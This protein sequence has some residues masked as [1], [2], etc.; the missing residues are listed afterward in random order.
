MRMKAQTVNSIFQQT[1]V[2]HFI[3]PEGNVKFG[4]DYYMTPKTTVGFVVSGFRN[5]ETDRSGSNIQLLNPSYVVELAGLFTQYQQ[6]FLEERFGE[7][8]FPAYL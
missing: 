6:D 2:M 3:N 7:P 4:M 8:E 1:T 5:T